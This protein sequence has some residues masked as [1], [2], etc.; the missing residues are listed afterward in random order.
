MKKAGILLIAL[1]FYCVLLAFNMDVVVGKTY[2]IG[3]LNERQNIV[4][5]SGILFLSGIMLFGFGFV[6]KEETKNIKAFALWTFLTPIVLP[7]GIKIVADIQEA[8][9]QNEIRLQVATKQKEQ[10]AADVKKQEEMRL[11]AAP[12]LKENSDKFVDNKDGTVTFKT[13][14]LMWQRCSFGQTWTGETCS[15]KATDITWYDAIKLTSN[16]AGHSDWRLPTR[17]ELITLVFC[18]NRE[19]KT[20]GKE[21]AGFICTGSVI[22]P[23]IN[24][25]YFPNTNSWFW[26]SSPFALISSD[27]AWYVGFNDG[28]SNASYKDSNSN[29]RLVRG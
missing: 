1:G 25:T 28:N 16:F 9:R 2:N 21:E 6:A 14:G 20:L 24:T 18:W 3:L 10:A 26:S 27:F 17:D 7:M 13:T 22:S 15:G 29:V 12:I 23:T 19:I 11:Q 8:N 5:L 4:Y